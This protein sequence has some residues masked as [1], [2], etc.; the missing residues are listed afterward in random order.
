MDYFMEGKKNMLQFRNYLLIG[1]IIILSIPVFAE[2]D[3]ELYD[4]FNNTVNAWINEEMTEIA[5]I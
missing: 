5:K 4:S 1:L 2:I 3:K